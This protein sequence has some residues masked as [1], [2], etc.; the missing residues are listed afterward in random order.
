MWSD[1]HKKENMINVCDKKCI[2]EGCNKSP[3]FNLPSEPNALYCLEHK[4]EG[5]IGKN[6]K[7]CQHYKCK[8]EAIY[9]FIGKR[10]QFCENHKSE[11]MVNL[12]TEY[13]CSKCEKEY[14]FIVDNCKFCLNHCPN[15][16]YEIKLK[17]KCKYCEHEE[18][19][20]VCNE[21]KQISTK[22]EWSVI[23]YIKK[24]IDTKFK[25]NTS[26]PVKECSNVRPDVFFDLVQHCVIVEI[27]ENQHKS[28]DSS[29]ECAR[30]NKIVN[31]IGGKSVIFIRYNPDKTYNTF[32]N[33]KEVKFEN[34]EKLNLLI[35]TIKKELEK[36]YDKICVKI[37]Q[38]FYDDDYEEYKKK[39]TE[40]ITKIVMC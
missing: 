29:C 40:D 3:N 14:E 20:F 19:N 27:D 6:S 1:T 8:S 32:K 24:N 23:R 22:K 9:G 26:E 17:R 5:M 4:K 36:K 31:S 25:H 16:E 10:K 38:L 39:K 18:S 37:I 34:K 11:T 7:K 35:K 15:K 2:H 12:E 13:K 30:I 33:K 21:C 28:Y